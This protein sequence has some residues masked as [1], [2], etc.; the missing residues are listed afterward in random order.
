MS[1][2]VVVLGMHRSGTSFLIRALNLAGLWLGDESELSTVEGRAM[3]GNPRGNYENRECIAI[4]NTLLA[5]Y[6][7]AW[8]KPPAQVLATREDIERIRRLCDTLQRSRPP[9]FPRWGWK[10]PRSVLT[11]NAWLPALTH[12]PFI[13]ASFRHPSA[14]ARSLLA[15]DRIPETLGLAL[16]AHYNARLIGYLQRFPHVLIQFDVEKESL[17]AQVVRACGVTGLSL[18]ATPIASW[19]DASLVRSN[20]DSPDPPPSGLRPLWDKLVELHHAQSF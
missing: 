17:L 19:Y 8:Y 13:V 5:R 14:V 2:P 3:P 15:R 9:D 11:L 20:I 7:A 16:W 10:D 4:N 18:D 1:S 12:S 6:G